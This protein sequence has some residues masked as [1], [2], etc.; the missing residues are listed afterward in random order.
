MSVASLVLV[1]PQPKLSVLVLDHQLLLDQPASHP[2]PL[3]H[4]SPYPVQY[5]LVPSQVQVSDYLLAWMH[6]QQLQ[7]E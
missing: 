7:L 1:H 4:Q 6:L 2:S 5:Q 3:H